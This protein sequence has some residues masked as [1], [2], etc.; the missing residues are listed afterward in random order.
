MLGPVLALAVGLAA[1]ALPAA[2]VAGSPSAT[3]TYG[4]N[5]ALASHGAVATSSGQE[6]PGR[7][8]P[9]LAI[10]GI[11][12][13]DDSRWSGEYAD[14]SWL[15]V[16]MAEP[17]LIDHVSIRWSTSCPLEYKLQVSDDGAVWTDV[18]PVLT[19]TECRTWESHDLSSLGQAHKYLRMQG[20]ERRTTQGF[21]Y[22]YSINEIEI[23]DGPEPPPPPIFPLTPRPASYVTAAGCTPFTVQPNAR[24]L[25]SGPG[26]EVLGQFAKQLR[27]ATGYRLPVVSGPARPGDIHVTVDPRVDIAVPGASGE[28]PAKYELV[29][30]SH[31]VRILA[32]QPQGAFYGIQSLRQLLP[33]WVEAASPVTNVSWEVPCVT[34]KDSP[35]FAY[36]GLMLDLAR[37][38]VSADQVKSFIDSMSQLKMNVLHLHLAD[39]QGWRIQITNDG[40]APGDDI[41][42]SLLTSV[43]GATAIGTGGPQDVPGR[44]GYLTQAQYRD[45]VAYA[46]SRFVTVVPEIDLPGHTNAILHAIPQLNTAGSVPQPPPGQST[47]P[48]DS[49]QRVG[50]TSLDTRAE[51]TY[52]FLAHVIHQLAALTPGTT[53]HVGGDEAASTAH[54]DYV[55]FMNRVLRLVHDEGKRAMGWNQYTDADL[56]AADVVQY[57]N[58]S[59]AGTVDAVRQKGAKVVVSWY[60]NTYLDYPYSQGDFDTYYGW[61]PAARVA[62]VPESSIEGVEAPLWTEN[63]RSDDEA[64]YQVYP[65]AVATAEV[66]WSAQDDRN[67]SDF[68]RRLAV[69]GGRFT[70]QHVNF[71]PSPRAPWAGEA[72]ALDRDIS[73]DGASNQQRLGMVL[74]PGSTPADLSVLVDWG[75]GTPMTAAELTTDQAPDIV[76][77]VGAYVVTGDHEY[78]HPGK[79]RARLVVA[80][81]AEPLEAPF[82]VRVGDRRTMGDT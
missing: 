32:N 62:G 67:V 63:V 70:L 24:F 8:G 51:V 49:S 48:A 38:F 65:R 35:R 56:H 42:Y 52:V 61:D 73:T 75:D 80:G 16:A 64:E 29:V 81:L 59:A 12:D 5:V 82:A 69:L 79:Y 37:N 41:D 66:G 72:L 55:Y 21:A 44:A 54:A 19:P 14:A 68:S 22:G 27:G 18:T 47:V 34:V 2:A 23:W 6:V 40:R 71:F 9:E 57:Y 53:L 4:T 43:S 33:T 10:D 46:A 3:P 15:Q 25:A 20:V 60:P 50:H 78:G 1:S 13:S 58:F 7:L 31:S 76:H 45:I 77:G 17:H 36:R 74:A 39:D 28:S 11:S 26:A 30:S